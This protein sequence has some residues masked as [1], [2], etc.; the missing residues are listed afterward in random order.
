MS[1]HEKTPFDLGKART[2]ENDL[3]RDEKEPS[4]AE[5]IEKCLPYAEKLVEAHQH[6]VVPRVEELLKTYKSY[7]KFPPEA[8]LKLAYRFGDEVEMIEAIAVALEKREN[9]TVERRKWF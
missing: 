1:Q 2:P 9:F 5:K 8:V 3:L 6:Q 7:E 4:H